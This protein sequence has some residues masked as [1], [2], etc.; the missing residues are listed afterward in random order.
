MMKSRVKPIAMAI[1]TTTILLFVASFDKV[2]GYTGNFKPSSNTALT[3][4]NVLSKFAKSAGY[5]W[6][7]VL[8]TTTKAD[9]A[10][11]APTKKIPKHVAER[12]SE[13][14]PLNQCFGQPVKKNCWSTEDVGS[15]K[16]EPWV[17]PSDLVTKGG[18]DAIFRDLQKTMQEYP[19]AGQGNIDG[20]G[21][22]IAEDTYS[23]DNGVHYTRYEFTSLR[24]KYVDDVEI[25]V[26]ANG[27]VSAR[28]SSRDGG[29]DVGVNAARMNYISSALEKK[30]WKVTLL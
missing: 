23:K 19:Q 5:G 16:L 3:R 2:S 27:N 10:V 20:G 12:G 18:S 22:N 21:W 26:D 8:G 15:R 9:V 1:F 24:F 25:R 28:S 14:K 7:V 29:F 4:K 30:G 17:P 13:N 6:L 11:A